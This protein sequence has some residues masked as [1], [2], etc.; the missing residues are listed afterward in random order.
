MQTSFA[1]G[2][3]PPPY[4][5]WFWGDSRLAFQ[6]VSNTW[7]PS[8]SRFVDLIG[9]G[10]WYQPK[11]ASGSSLGNLLPSCKAQSWLWEPLQFLASRTVES[12]PRP[13]KPAIGRIQCTPGVSWIPDGGNGIFYGTVVCILFCG[14]L[15][16]CQN[17]PL[18]YN[19]LSLFAI[20]VCFFSSFLYFS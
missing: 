9:H 14:L 18:I 19:R 7:S 8:L 2:P 17:R 12:V 4:V 5:F 13:G 10:H 3:R 1:H 16:K 20:S 6:A 11:N 15:S